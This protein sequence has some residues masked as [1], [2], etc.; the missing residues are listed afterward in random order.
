MQ[1][2]S[3]IT[4]LVSLL[5]AFQGVLSAQNSRMESSINTNWEFNKTDLDFSGIIHCDTAWEK[6]NLPHS[7][8]TV[9]AYDDA[10]GYYRGKTWY[11]KTFYL[12][13]SQLGKNLYLYFEGAYQKTG[14]YVNGKIAGT[15]VG[16]Y[17][18][19]CFDI[20]HLVNIDQGVRS[21]NEIYISVDNSW[22]SDVPALG[23]DFSFYGGIYRDVFIV[24]T[25]KTHF[26]LDDYASNG[27]YI[28]TPKVTSKKATVHIQAIITKT[29]D[30]KSVLVKNILRDREGKIV[31]EKS[32]LMELK[33]RE[34]MFETGFKIEAP[35]LWSIETPYLYTLESVLLD[36]ETKKEI[37]FVSNTIGFR[38]YAFTADEGF[39]LNGESIKLIGTN[40]HQD[41][42]GL[43]N[44]LPDYIHH[45]DIVNLKKMG[46]NVLRISHYPQD[47]VIIEMCDKLGIVA[48][49]EIPIVGGISFT[50][51]FSNNALHMMEE[52][53][54]QN[55]NHPSVLIW[56]YMNEILFVDRQN[57]PEKWALMA[58]KVRALAQRIEDKTRTLDPYRYTMIP[59]QGTFI[60]YY[61]AGLTEIPMIVGWNLY[62]GWYEPDF[63]SFNQYMELHREKLPHKPVLIT[64][65]GAGSDPRL[66]SFD[67]KR[68]DFSVEYQVKYHQHYLKTIKALDFVAGGMV[69]NL[70]DFGSEG[71]KDAV[72]HVNNKGLVSFNRVPKES[73]Y[74]YQ[75]ML[76]KEPVVLIGSKSW[77]IRSSVSDSLDDHVA[78]MPVTVYSNMK[79]AQMELNGSLLGKKQLVQNQATFHVP[80][81]DG[82]NNL[83][84]RGRD[85]DKELVDVAN[86]EFKI[87]PFYTLDADFDFLN[88][89]AGSHMYFTENKT[90]RTWL[91]DKPYAEGS[92]GYIGGESYRETTR[93]GYKYTSSKT[94]HTTDN[95][96][97]YQTQRIKP[98]AY[99]FDVP[100]GEYMVEL[101]FSELSSSERELSVSINHRMVL[102]NFN[103]AKEIGDSYPFIQKNRV[104]VGDERRI[105]IEFTGNKGDAVVNGISIRKI[106]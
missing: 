92:W 105:V 66:H 43:A 19:F 64:E 87:L 42:E 14:V 10:E 79:S 12:D 5:L 61:D 39:T 60:D 15:H 76:S 71:R 6:V 63:I 46:G 75:A 78:T 20:S 106:N 40:R 59:N 32:E 77:D 23:G 70:N 104:V 22:D 52:M 55:Y 25:N 94:I 57:D 68:F 73:F 69:W 84:A 31:Y 96:P 3:F 101:Y 102:S 26:S 67:S 89:N 33:I 24:A 21:K 54:K 65:Y 86:I 38:W 81:V 34:N 18:R 97:I 74:F 45:S 91:P 56:A 88:V 35:T 9:D 58:D 41:Y 37:D 28:T 95:E 82:T 16:G 80:F 49:V 48:S 2:K 11:K 7:Y 100:Y 30:R 90:H 85:D 53:V 62:M 51:E 27:I 47:P 17:T 83:V 72:T 99:Q 44:A 13:P 93:Y 29:D 36:P 50:E 8:N 1:Q 98:E 4:L 103:L